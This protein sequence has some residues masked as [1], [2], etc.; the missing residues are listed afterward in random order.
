MGQLSTWISAVIA[1]VCG[2]LLGIITTIAHRASALIGDW[3]APM[4]LIL[5]L[6]AVL[7]LVLG[8]RLLWEHRLPALGAGIGVVVAE[9]F[10]AQAGRALFLADDA[11]TRTWLIAPALLAALIVVWPV[12]RAAPPDRRP[13]RAD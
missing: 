5:G 11:V 4:G 13:A 8:C 9:I 2:V 3:T 7:A 6:V 1:L 12:R 10:V